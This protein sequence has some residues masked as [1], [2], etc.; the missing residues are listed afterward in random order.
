MEE[1]D[2]GETTTPQQS[3][4]KSGEW[5]ESDSGIEWV[6]ASG[7]KKKPGEEEDTPLRLKPSEDRNNDDDEDTFTKG[8]YCM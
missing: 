2:F 8:L 6:V 5:R 4:N 3:P 1:Q 7:S